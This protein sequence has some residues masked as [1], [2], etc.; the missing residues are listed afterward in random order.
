MDWL[1]TQISD[2]KIPLGSWIAGF[3]DFLINNF[4]TFFDL[5]SALL[6]F[7][8][9]GLTTLMQ[10]CPPLALIASVAVLAWW[11]HRSL[12]LVLGIAAFLLLIINQGYWEQTLETLA[13]VF[14]ATLICMLIGIPI[15]IAAAH[16]PWLYAAIR[17]I[18]DLM[19][20][21]PTFV[22]SSPL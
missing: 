21:I 10:A 7:V 14:F 4:A 22:Y 18:L 11:L 20:T 8:I 5:L 16:R 1:T 12:W 15:G 19:Q 13:L 6:E 17:P 9:E 2:H 3:F